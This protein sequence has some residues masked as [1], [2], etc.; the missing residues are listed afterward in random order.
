[1]EPLTHQQIREI[2]AQER[3]KPVIPNLAPVDWGVLDYF[4]WIHPAGHRGYV[5]MPLAN[6]ELRGVILRRTQSS[7]RR[8][9][10]EMCSWC[11]HVHRANG[12]AMFSVVVRGSDGRK[13]I[14]N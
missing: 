6:G 5:V 13:T 11:N 7:P 2:F 10:Y 8:P 1:M 12:T 4:G 3:E 14:G 9:R